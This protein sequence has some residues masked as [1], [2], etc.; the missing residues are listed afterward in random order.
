ARL[1]ESA[2]EEDAQHVEDDRGD[3]D[4]GGPVMRLPHQQPGAHLEREVD[5]GAVGDAH[6]VPAERRIV[7]G[8]V[9]RGRA[10]LEEE[11]QV[12]AG[13]GSTGRNVGFRKSATAQPACV[14]IFEYATT[15]PGAQSRR[16]AGR[17]SSDGSKRTTTSG[18]PTSS[19]SAP[20]GYA[21]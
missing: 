5:G 2:G 11:G 12:D 15:P 7:P 17:W 9:G 8:V 4:V 6:L 20:S 13:P 14:Q 1:P 21:V 18:E 3:E 19:L 10:R 16:P